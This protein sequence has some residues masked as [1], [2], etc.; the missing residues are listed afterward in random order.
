MKLS[1]VTPE[2]FRTALAL[3]LERAYQ[4]VHP[5][6]KA[7]ID[8]S[9]LATAQDVLALFVPEPRPN[10][11][12]ETA[13]HYVL[14]LGNSRYPHMKVALME[15]LE[16][17][18]WIWAVDTHDRAPITPDSP[19]YPRWQELRLHNLRVKAEVEAAWRRHGVPTARVV[20]RKLPRVGEK[21]C[22]GPLVLVVDDEKGMRTAAVMMLR[23][24]GYRVIEAESGME[25][26]ERFVHDRPDL[27]L[28][29]YEMPGMDGEETCR[30]MR[31]IGA[32]HEG[33]HEGSHS[34]DRRTPILL[35]TAGM[36]PLQQFSMADGFLVKPY[37]RTLLLSFVK[38]QLPWDKR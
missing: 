29:D 12:G 28:M 16:P 23:A 32:P 31:E 35:C 30:R 25:A 33:G 27:V 37:Q 3:Y 18:E 1:E 15:F 10:P 38:H 19:D 22:H 4:G 2:L 8:T 21:D 17:G 26:I 13:H 24:Q 6:A 7:N 11:G 9:R 34:G 36:V 14:R 20:Q 5:P